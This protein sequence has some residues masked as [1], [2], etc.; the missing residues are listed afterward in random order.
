MPDKNTKVQLK[1]N[2]N[3]T[4]NALHCIFFIGMDHLLKQQ[5]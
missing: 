4:E 5:I 2:N 3:L 1:P